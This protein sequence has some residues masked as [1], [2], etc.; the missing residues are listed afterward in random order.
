LIIYNPT[1]EEYESAKTKLGLIP[2]KQYEKHGIQV[3]NENHGNVVRH[4]YKITQETWQQSKCLTNSYQVGLRDEQQAIVTM[5]ESRRK[6][7][8][9][10]K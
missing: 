9:D 4:D 7:E 8:D 2:V 5:C 1:W 10:L 6:L 3:N